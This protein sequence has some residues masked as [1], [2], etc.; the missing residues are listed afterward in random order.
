[1]L[2]FPYKQSST[3]TRSPALVLLLAIVLAVIFGL[4]LALGIYPIIIIL[5]L[6]VLGPLLVVY[7]KLGLWVSIVGAL[8][9]AGLIDLYFPALRPLKWGVT[10][11]TIALLTISLSIAFLTPVIPRN[12]SK[13][14]PS[15]MMWI[16]GFV[17]FV[18]FSSLL[19]WGGFSSLSVG[20]KGYFQVWGLLFVV[21]YLIKDEQ[22][23]AKLMRF[24][25]ILGLIQL[26]FVLHQFI[27]LVPKRSGLLAA[28]HNIVAVDIVA[29]TFGGSMSGGGRSS[30]LALLIAVCITMLLASWRAHLTSMR[31]MTFISLILFLPLLL[32]EAKIIVVL[33]PI[34]LFL[35]FYD[36]IL[37]NPFRFI[38]GLG[39]TSLLLS[40][41]F[42]TYLLLPGA[43]PAG[44]R[45]LESVYRQTLEYNVGR[46]GYGGLA[47][48]R[49]TVYK[50][51]F[52]EHLQLGSVANLLIGHGPGQTNDGSAI[53]SNSLSTTRYPG[54]GIGLTG[55]SAMLWEIGLM[56]TGMA[57]ALLLSAY[58]LGEK[59]AKHWLNTAHWP[60]IKAAQIAMPLFGINL[61]HNNF[62]IVDLSYQALFVLLVSYLLV[63]SRFIKKPFES[64]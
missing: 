35:L 48:N 13:S 5:I 27:V 4:L 55:F 2:L 45:S 43:Q 42:A 63:M 22:D 37:T 33:L 32:N 30:S 40:A 7:P 38:A 25:L 21:Y 29:G 51:W 31:R 12:L 20:L 10:I 39:I 61:F 56:G 28:E 49:L 41:L 50:F 52:S 6:L 36:R 14:P 16:L 26:P 46:L 58:R 8:V 9:F 23:A 24:L 59:L 11:L 34:M 44:G 62:F 1:M 57:M 18:V 60:L 54:Y 15:L 19:N 3:A 17:L 47:L 53:L 64:K